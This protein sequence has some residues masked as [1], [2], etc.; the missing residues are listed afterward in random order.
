[1]FRN[2]GLIVS[3]FLGLVFV[4]LSLI[5]LL[6]AEASKPNLLGYYSLCSWVP[7]STAILFSLAFASFVFAL[8]IKRGYT[9][10]SMFTEVKIIR[11]KLMGCD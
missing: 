1:M 6:P 11:H 5:T 7:N 8:R 4:L 2:V 9:R 3:G 10:E